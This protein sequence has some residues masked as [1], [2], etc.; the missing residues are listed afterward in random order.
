LLSRRD[1]FVGSGIGA[2][3]AVAQAATQPTPVCLLDM[4][5]NIGG[6]SPG[7]GTV[8]LDA[9][10]RHGVRKAFVCLADARSVEA[11]ARAGI[12]G[13]ATLEMGGKTDRRHG[14]PI[15]AAVRVRGLYD[16]QFSESQ[17]RHGGR[18]DYNMGATAIV[19][20]EAG[21]TVML[22]SRRTAPF[23][24]AQLTSCNVDPR[25][26]EIIVAKGVHA[27]LAA[28]APVCPTVVR[29]DTP[30]VTTADMTRLEYHHRRRPLFPFEADA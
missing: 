3:E 12:G 5:D 1:T 7:D 26:F 25:A 9:I 14:A 23:S 11:A 20:L 21:P 10:L 17:P 13:R 24:L 4:G 2:D 22:T 8:L 16:G 28:Y 19:D 6:G 15:T 18:I 30:G 27:P 29:V